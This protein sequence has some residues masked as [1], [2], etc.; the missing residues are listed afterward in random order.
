MEKHI[1][2]HT[3]L[4]IAYKAACV[5]RLDDSKSIHVSFHESAEI[6]DSSWLNDEIRRRCFWAT[7]LTHCINSEHYTIGTSVN[8]R[9]MDLPLPINND[10]FRNRTYEPLT[11]TRIELDKIEARTLPHDRPPPLPSVMAE[12]VKL[13]MIW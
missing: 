7:W 12:L 8:N 9:I 11:T 2:N 6:S 5:L 1:T 3:V 10:S 13:M 4:G